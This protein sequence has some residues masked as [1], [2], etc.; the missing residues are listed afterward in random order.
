[1]ECVDMLMNNDKEYNELVSKC[2]YIKADEI[3]D[4]AVERE[5]EINEDIIS[6]NR[7]KRIEELEKIIEEEKKNK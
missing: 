2:G 3:W 1:M 5:N 6:I 4:A 7:C